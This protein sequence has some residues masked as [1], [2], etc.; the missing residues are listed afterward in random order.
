MLITH[1][2]AGDRFIDPVDNPVDNSGDNFCDL[3]IKS[4]QQ[5]IN[6]ESTLYQQSY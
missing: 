6:N 5:V 1:L 2:N 4:Y 3:W